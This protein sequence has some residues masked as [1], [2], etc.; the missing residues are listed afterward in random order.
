MKLRMLLPFTLLTSLGPCDMMWYAWV[1]YD[2]PG[3]GD[4][5]QAGNTPNCMSIGVQN[6]TNERDSVAVLRAAGEACGIIAS[7]EFASA[8]RARTWLASCKT[9]GGMPD[10]MSGEEVYRQISSKLPSFSVH[11]RK[12]WGAIAQAHKDPNGDPAQSR[13]AINP[14]QIRTWYSD[15]PWEIVNTIAHETTH[16]ISYDFQD[17]GHGTN[18]CPDSALVSYGVGNLV[19]RLWKANRPAG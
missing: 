15:E 8:V 12:P 3:Q 10:Q 7:P 5:Q 16:I 19:E 17:G 18:A 11:P 14:K 4:F 1:G 13:V 2:A 9:P 6:L